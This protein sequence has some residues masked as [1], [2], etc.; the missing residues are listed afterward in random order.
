MP[1]NTVALTAQPAQHDRLV[2]VG[3]IA[4]RFIPGSQLPRVSCLTLLDYFILGSTVLVFMA[5]L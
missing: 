4:F 3:L 2:N 1:G 5:L